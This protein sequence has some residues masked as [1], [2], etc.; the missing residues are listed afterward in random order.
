MTL[1]PSSLAAIAV[2]VLASIVMACLDDPRALRC[3]KVQ[4]SNTVGAWFASRR[5]VASFNS[6]QH[7]PVRVG[8]PDE[9]SA[10]FM[11]ARR[12]TTT[13]VGI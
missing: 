7:K 5:T 1:T 11:V 3:L 8:K 9:H 6:R 4:W 10:G 2:V 13:G 12:D